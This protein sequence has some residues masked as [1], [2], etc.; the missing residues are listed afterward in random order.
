[1]APILDGSPRDCR[2][3][4]HRAALT[5]RHRLALATGR[6]LTGAGF[7]ATGLATTR[8]VEKTDLPCVSSAS[9]DAS[10]AG[11]CTATAGAGGA[12]AGDSVLLYALARI[13]RSSKFTVPLPSRS[14]S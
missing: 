10:V 6:G 12:A 11:A 7:G 1:M 5:S 9:T 4:G 3:R 13:S 8:V 2:M 14:P